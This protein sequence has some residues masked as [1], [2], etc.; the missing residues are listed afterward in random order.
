MS[1]TNQVMLANI[2]E[3]S[4]TLSEP[5]LNKFLDIVD[6]LGELLVLANQDTEKSY[7]MYL[8]SL[9]VNVSGQVNGQTSNNNPLVNANTQNLASNVVQFKH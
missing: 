7:Q 4:E 2:Q 9:E 5:Q 8:N 6:S 3:F 1:N